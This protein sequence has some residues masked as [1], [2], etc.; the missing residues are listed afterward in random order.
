MKE[1]SYLKPSLKKQKAYQ[2]AQEPELIKLNQNEL[3]YDLPKDLQKKLAARL[4]KLPLNRYPVMEPLRLKKALAQKLKL[5]PEQIL[6]GTGSNV[7]LQA[8]V[9]SLK[10][11]SLVLSVSPSF[12]LYEL[13]PKT[14]GYPFA[15][16]RLRKKDFTLEEGKFLRVVRQKKP[17]LIFLANPN[18][19]TGGLY[20]I[21]FIKKLLEQTSG[22]VL[23]DEAYFEFSGVTLI[24]ELK[25]FS[26]LLI[27]RTFSKAYGLGGVRVGYLLGHEDLLREIKKAMVPFSVGVLNEEAALFALEHQKIFKEKIKE[28]LAEKEKLY[29]SMARLKGLEVFPSAANFLLFRVNDALACFTHLK[30]KGILVRNVS[31]QPD[32]KGCL[33]VT[34]G[35][36]SENQ[37]FLK[38]L[39][40]AIHESPWRTHR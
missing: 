14:F 26:N 34:V 7:L 33:R 39:V 16:V 23:V 37:K 28:V 20:S 13:I 4:V 40:G 3:P 31:G 24:K 5:K 19:P 1:L 22:L 8:L 30:K 32:L 27:N 18:A 10:E 38:A 17:S 6:V 35:T 9:L 36:P 11:K 12:A 29:Q 25:K 15:G 2:V 21:D